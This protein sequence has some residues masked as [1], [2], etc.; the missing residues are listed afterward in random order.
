MTKRPFYST[1]NVGCDV[2][3]KARIKHEGGIWCPPVLDKKY[4][5]GLVMSFCAKFKDE[6]GMKIKV[7]EAGGDKIIFGLDVHTK[8]N[9]LFEMI[10]VYGSMENQ[11]TLEIHDKESWFHAHICYFFEKCVESYNKELKVGVWFT[12]T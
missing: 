8:S 2:C 6:F 7:R 12:R 11:I 5:R 10:V 9:K 4:F 1:S 3:G